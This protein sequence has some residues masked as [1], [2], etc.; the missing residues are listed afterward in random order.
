MSGVNSVLWIIGSYIVIIG[1]GIIIINFLT[2]GYMLVYFKVKASMG[3]KLLVRV[4]DVI[5][6]YYK[7]GYIDH[8]KSLLFKDRLGETHTF[9]QIDMNDVGRE[10]GLNIVEV[11]IVKGTFINRDK[12]K[13]SGVDTATVDKMIKRAIQ[14]KDVLNEDNRMKILLIIGVVCLLGIIFIGYMIVI[15]GNAEVICNYIPQE[16]QI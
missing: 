14:L 6:T 13:S 2:K 9:N 10:L 4:T 1:L 12:S 5:D 15:S 16:V 8:N 3:K 7:S 11:D